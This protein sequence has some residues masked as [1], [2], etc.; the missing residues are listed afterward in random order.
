M[1][2]VA[3][4]KFKLAGGVTTAGAAGVVVAGFGAV[5]VAAGVGV[6][7]FGATAAAT[8]CGVRPE[9]DAVCQDE[10]FVP[11][12]LGIGLPDVSTG[13]NEVPLELRS[14]QV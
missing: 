14:I 10:K 11:G 7:G 1:A 6:T 9:D 4:G 5:V 13:N 3:A 2:V 12:V 8:C